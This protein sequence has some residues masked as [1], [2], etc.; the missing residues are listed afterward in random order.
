MPPEKLTGKGSNVEWASFEERDTVFDSM[1]KKA[2]ESIDAGD[3]LAIAVNKELLDRYTTYDFNDK[4]A[5]LSS[6]VKNVI[7]GLFNDSEAR[8]NLFPAWIKTEDDLNEFVNDRSKR[9]DDT[10]RNFINF[11]Y[12]AVRSGMAE[13]MSI[14]RILKEQIA[15][16]VDSFLNKLLRRWEIIL[17]FPI[18][19]LSTDEKILRARLMAYMKNED[20]LDTEIISQF[21]Q[22]TSMDVSCYYLRTLKDAKPRDIILEVMNEKHANQRKN[23]LALIEKKRSDSAKKIQGEREQAEQGIDAVTKPTIRKAAHVSAPQATETEDTTDE[24]GGSDFTYTETTGE[25]T[26]VD[27][28]RIP[29]APKPKVSKP[30]SEY[31]EKTGEVTD[32][33]DELTRVEPK[34]IKLD[35]LPVPASSDVD[36]GKTNVIPPVPGVAPMAQKP[37]KHDVIPP[38]SGA[39]L[40]AS[41]KVKISDLVEEK[42]EKVTVEVDGENIT[43]PALP[44]FEGIEHSTW[45]FN[46]KLR[47]AKHWVADNP[48]KVAVTIAF[49]VLSITGG[50]AYL[51]TKKDEVKSLK[52]KNKIAAKTTKD[53]NSKKIIKDLPKDKKK[54]AMQAPMHMEPT[55]APKEVMKANKDLSGPKPIKKVKKVKPAPTPKPTKT[56]DVKSAMSNPKFANI[57]TKTIDD[58]PD[59]IYKQMWQGKKFRLDNVSYSEFLQNAY[60]DMINKLPRRERYKAKYAY[61]QERR[62]LEKGWLIYNKLKE[63]K[64]VAKA[65]TKEGLTEKEAAQLKDWNDYQDSHRRRARQARRLLSKYER[66]MKSKKKGKSYKKYKDLLARGVELMEFPGLNHL[67]RSADNILPHEE[68]SFALKDG[69]V[70]KTNVRFARAIKKKA[71]SFPMPDLVKGK[72]TG[73]IE[74]VPTHVMFAETG[75]DKDEIQLNESDML[76][77]QPIKKGLATTAPE[78]PKAF[79]SAPLQEL[80]PVLGK[81]LAKKP[82]RIPKDARV[83]QIRRE[84]IIEEKMIKPKDYGSQPLGELKPVLAKMMMDRKRPP[85]IPEDALPEIKDE[86]I[87]EVLSATP[88]PIPVE[89]SQIV[90][91]K[92]MAPVPKMYGSAPLPKEIKP[93]LGVKPPTIPADTKPDIYDIPRGEEN[94]APE[95]V[96]ITDNR[97][98]KVGPPPIPAMADVP[99]E[100]KKTSLWGRAKGWL[101]RKVA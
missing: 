33:K 28:K 61:K 17:N 18:S 24:G 101:K 99:K 77:V 5:E 84:D 66:A 14:K 58:L 98:P 26:T 87:V 4:N 82:P 52:E 43:V 76:D 79:G 67:Q 64:L 40:P 44:S 80:K 41:L 92:K 70:L 36:E 72:K 63:K 78:P 100:P 10:A 74:E 19:Q 11:V 20:Q 21:N 16:Q 85:A 39:Q 29:K 55:M 68:V 88:P 73:S 50:I 23:M 42:E 75:V 47:R 56:I 89:D 34:P 95:Y 1:R 83:H 90:Y 71:K 35:P 15:S 27:S 69:R 54:P 12:L 8:E 32:V 62:K 65:L 60:E 97:M 48:K 96:S 59:G 6:V 22:D 49:V 3:L 94:E 37:A 45:K 93:I 86:D 7:F 51:T 91:E 46:E 30:V 81:M 9:T 53:D 38:M 2:V 13:L 57:D 31:S 25:I